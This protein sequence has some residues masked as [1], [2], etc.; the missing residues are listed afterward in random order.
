M[1]YV[2]FSHEHFLLN[3]NTDFIA[4]ILFFKVHYWI[5]QFKSKKSNQYF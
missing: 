4:L 1:F 3:C 2:Q 5:F